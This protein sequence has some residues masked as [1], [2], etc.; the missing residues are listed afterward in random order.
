VG[1]ICGGSV[2]TQWLKHSA[3]G[4]TGEVE[5]RLDRNRGRFAW[6]LEERL[7]LTIMIRAAQ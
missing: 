1:G 6:L 3:L 5:L 7:A 4:K 2:V